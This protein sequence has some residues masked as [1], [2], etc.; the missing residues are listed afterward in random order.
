MEHPEEES[1]TEF[2]DRTSGWSA[3]Q[4]VNNFA[5]REKRRMATP[6]NYRACAN[7]LIALEQQLGSEKAAVKG[8]RDAGASETNLKNAKQLVRVYDDYVH[9]GH[10]S[11]AWFE[12]LD[13]NRT[14]LVNQATN[15]HD[16]WSLRKEPIFNG[17]PTAWARIEELARSP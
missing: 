14:I 5:D 8:L 4:L 3:E 11:L 10:A 7:W 2:R 13:Y 1:F 17:T 16:R 15:R 9:S 6:W 12:K